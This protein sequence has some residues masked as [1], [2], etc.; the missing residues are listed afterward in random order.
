MVGKELT[1]EGEILSPGPVVVAGVV[2]GSIKTSGAVRVIQGGR[3]EGPVEGAQVLI[4]GQVEGEVAATDQVE[5]RA[6]GRVDGEIRAPRVAM[7]EGA[8]IR[9][10]VVCAGGTVTRFVDRRDSPGQ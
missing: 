6:S 1:V 9:G 8:F 2:L 10:S 4:E 3:V 7:E 5:L